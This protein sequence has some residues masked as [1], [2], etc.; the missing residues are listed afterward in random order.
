MGDGRGGHWLVRMEWHPAGWSVCLLLVI[1][2]CTTK[3][4]ISLLALAHPG[5][6]GKMAIERLWCGGGGAANI[7]WDRYSY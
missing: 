7:L 5:C 3:S 2:L 1:F 4:R 6:P